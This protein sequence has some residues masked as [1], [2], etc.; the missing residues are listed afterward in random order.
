MST[1]V[2]VVGVGLIGAS[3][4][5]ALTRRGF[6]VTLSDSSPTAVALAADLGAGEPETDEAPDLVVVATPP[7][8]A[9]QVL[10]AELQRWPSAVV[11][12]IASVKSSVLQMLRFQVGP[13]DLARYVGSH[14]MAGRERSGTVAARA[15]LF[16]GRT[17]VV[18][19]T[20]ASSE[21][22]VDLVSRVG[23]AT[24]AAVVR[25]SA[26]E[27]DR[28]VAA[29]SHLPQLAASLVAAR[30]TP[31][32]DGEVGLAGQ[33][34][35]DVTRI[36]ASDPMLW[37]QIVAGNATSLV[38]VLDA[39]AD[40]LAALR[41][42]VGELAAEQRGLPASAGARGVVA[43]AIADGQEGQARIPGKHGGAA[44]AYASVVVV[45]PDEPGSLARL[46][47]ACGEA[48][49]SIEDVRIEHAGGR[50]VG[51]VELWVLPSVRAELAEALQRDGW[52]VHG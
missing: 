11:T 28:A 44:T 48:G 34:L 27:H 15:D 3:I 35:R 10:G 37:T 39:V 47:H 13:D 36:A 21:H 32:S 18:C 43:R 46:F 24:D 16:E 42:A 19:P 8:V 52:S 25:M 23:A 12:D 7:D 50:P 41:S 49:V 29:I 9:A 51:L 26:E 30:L 17:W 33:G 38:P 2:R 45:I 4:G 6:R 20:D 22:A 14:P 40:D 5:L 31:L 1:H